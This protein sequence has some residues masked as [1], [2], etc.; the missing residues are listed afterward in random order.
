MTNWSSSDEHAELSP[1]T[2]DQRVWRWFDYLAMWAVLTTSV[3]VLLMT[4]PLFQY[5]LNWWQISLAILVSQLLSCIFTLL[6]A[7]PGSR[8]GVPFIA[9]ARGT[10]GIVGANYYV[11]FL[12]F[13]LSV[14][15]YG[16]VVYYS[17]ILIASSVKQ[18]WSI[19]FN[20]L[21]NGSVLPSQMQVDSQ[22]LIW[23]G[24]VWLLHLPVSLLRTKAMRYPIIVVAAI[25]S[26]F[27]VVLTIYL[28]AVY[29]QAGPLLSTPTSFALQNDSGKFALVFASAVAL[30]SG[31]F[32]TFD[33]SISDFSRL[34]LTPADCWLTS[35]VAKPVLVT[36]FSAL[37][38]ICMSKWMSVYTGPEIDMIFENMRLDVYVSDGNLKVVVA[39]F[40]LFGSVAV[41]WIANVIPGSLACIAMNEKIPARVGGLI[42]AVGGLLSYPLMLLIQN[43]I[44]W[45]N[46]TIVVGEVESYWSGVSSFSMFL[47]PIVGIMIADYFIVNEQSIDIEELGYPVGKYWF[48]YGVNLRTVG[49]YMFA[50][51]C[52]LVTLFGR[53]DTF[54][55]SSTFEWD[56][57]AAF[58]HWVGFCVGI[59]AYLL[60]TL[61]WPIDLF[62]DQSLEMDARRGASFGKHDDSRNI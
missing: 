14:F 29:P 2:F 22:H 3:P 19:D 42:V 7:Q 47:A 27:V 15:G 48:T 26:L 59:S 45:S 4:L 60:I 20:N 34:A 53:F 62:F 35:L 43:G 10:F 57:V 54:S 5:G 16:A 12:R 25:M 58:G 8:Y 61:I 32:M 49:A 24:L 21:T 31:Y 1:T 50:L 9:A 52:Q 36:L 39:I 17:A 46:V 23:F 55:F 13:I 30:Y 41:N 40:V 28:A 56:A 18:Q 44:N 6:M 51:M 38:M 33:T 37:G 11:G